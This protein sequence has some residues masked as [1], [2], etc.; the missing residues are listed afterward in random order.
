MRA[1]VTP[2]PLNRRAPALALAM[3]K[4]LREPCVAVGV[5]ALKSDVG[6]GGITQTLRQHIAP[7]VSGAAFRDVFGVAS[8]PSYM[9]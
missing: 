7:D 1:L 6:V 8:A 5:D 2:L 3:D 4:M 9:G